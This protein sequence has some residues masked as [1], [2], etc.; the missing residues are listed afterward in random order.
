MHQLTIEID[1][2]RI[3]AA[4]LRAI[5]RGQKEEEGDEGGGV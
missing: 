2:A 3:D 1:E 4:I 5:A